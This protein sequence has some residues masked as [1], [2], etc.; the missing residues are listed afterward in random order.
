MADV[1]HRILKAKADVR[2]KLN[3]Y[4]RVLKIA[5]KP[6]REEYMMAA[7]VTVAGT[8]IIGIIGFLF[9]LADTLLLPAV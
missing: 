2:A 7:K 3:E 1:K 4:I 5:E 8:L 6:D 9:Y